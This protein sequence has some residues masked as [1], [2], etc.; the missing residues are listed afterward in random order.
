MPLFFLITGDMTLL[1]IHSAIQ[2]WQSKICVTFKE[3]QFE[4][5]YIE[6]TY[7]GGYVYTKSKV[8]GVGERITCVSR[9]WVHATS[10]GM[11]Y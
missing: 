4:E 3:R 8:G 1:N 11:V 6:F 9:M 10:K 7:D 5:D 2:E